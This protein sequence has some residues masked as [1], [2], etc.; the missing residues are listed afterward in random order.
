MLGVE[1]A[2]AA[3][4]AAFE[5]AQVPFLAELVEESS[6]SREPED[7]ERLA[8]RVDRMAQELGL[9]REVHPDPEK[10]V[11][12]HRVYVTPATSADAQAPA[13]V[14]H[15]DTV[16]PRAMGFS[17]FR[18]EGDEARGPGVLD[19]KSGVTSMFFAL[20]ALESCRPGSIARLPLRIVLVS[21]EEIGSPSSRVLYAA[22]APKVSEALVFEAGRQADRIVTARK[23][24]GLYTVRARGRAAH[25]GN[26]HAEG[27]SAIW[28]L[29]LLVPRIEAR[30]D[31]SAGVTVNVGLFEGGSAKNTVPQHAAIG[32]DTRFERGDDARA[33][34][35]FMRAL[36]ERPFEGLEVPGGLREVLFSLEGGITRPPMEATPQ[37]HALRV[38]YEACAQRAG[39]G[40]G[41][42]PLQGGGSDANLLS[43]L[44]VPCIDGLGPYGRFFHET[45][46]W[47]SLSSLERRTTALTLH[48][49]GAG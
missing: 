43:A 24:G 1:E 41:E 29:S 45:R 4:H 25:A 3:V 28:A 49:A 34:D 37:S 17:G 11:A 6:C 33:L 8:E 14:G 22:L 10:R 38:R 7:V 26:A 15:L 16:F 36:I 40:I 5:A 12:A 27:R 39:L 30:T 46:E 44:G 9:L 32:I 42:A 21:D 13:L 35:A 48:L 47:C 23:G 31:Y 20:R 2:Q 19:M 18:R